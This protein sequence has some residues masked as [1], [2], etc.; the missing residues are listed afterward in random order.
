MILYVV[1]IIS[2][3]LLFLVSSTATTTTLL[4][5]QSVRT[6]DLYDNFEGSPHTITDNQTSP[7]GKWFNKYSG[8]GAS[9]TVKITSL[10]TTDN[11]TVFYEKPKT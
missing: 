11:N 6:F 5:P 10:T 2:T 4:L 1:I 7:N 8:F 3:I 9:G